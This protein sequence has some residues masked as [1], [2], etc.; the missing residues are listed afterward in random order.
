MIA[1]YRFALSP[2]DDPTISFDELAAYASDHNQRMSAHNPGGTALSARIAATATSLAAYHAALD[3][4]QSK[5]GLRKG[6][7]LVKDN[8]R[9]DLTREAEKIV[10]A[11]IAEY[12]GDSPQVLSVVP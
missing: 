10:A 7:K 4:D 12:G 6:A 5:L 3:S 8:F 11:V 9:A 2:I 1:L